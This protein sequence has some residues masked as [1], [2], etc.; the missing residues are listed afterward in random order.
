MNEHFVDAAGVRLHVLEEGDGPAVLVL[1]G[2]T[3]DAESMAPVSMGLGAR[4]RVFRLELVGHGKSDSP[5]SISA[6]SMEACAAQVGEASRALGLDRPHLLGYSMGGRTALAAAINE[7]EAFSSLVLIGATAGIADAALR[8]LRIA[9]DEALAER[10]ER[11]GVENFVDDWMAQPLFASQKRLG[12]A[13]LARARTQRLRNSADRLAKSLRGMGAGA[14]PPLH[15]RL[16]SLSIP[17]LLVVGDED[18]KFQK[19]AMDLEAQLPN[20]EVARVQQ[21]GHAAHLENPVAFARIVEEFWSKRV[22]ARGSND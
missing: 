4:F 11:E 2:F 22:P 5:R 18:E 13:A 16:A 12:A 10:I 9:S 1:H 20:A 8:K 3:G 17:V 21:A 6:F 15:D 14:Q 19:I 7:P